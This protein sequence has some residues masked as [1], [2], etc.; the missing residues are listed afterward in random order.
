MNR[1]APYRQSLS[2]EKR[3]ERILRRSAFVRKGSEGQR[4]IARETALCDAAI[5]AYRHQTLSW[6]LHFHSSSLP[7]ALGIVVQDGLS[8][9]APANHMDD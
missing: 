5:I 6:Q 9:S 8:A 7:R 4:G 1:T 2:L 3:H